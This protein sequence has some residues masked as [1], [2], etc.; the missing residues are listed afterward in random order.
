MP[1][2][3][4]AAVDKVR[5]FG[6]LSAAAWKY[7]RRVDKLGADQLVGDMNRLSDI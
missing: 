1:F 4:I 5:Q 2:N 3:R 7:R 6:L